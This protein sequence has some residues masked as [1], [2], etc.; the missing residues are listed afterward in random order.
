MV[1]KTQMLSGDFKIKK[2]KNLTLKSNT[3]MVFPDRGHL[4]HVAS[5]CHSSRMDIT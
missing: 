1:L 2:K 3:K 4:Q 5:L